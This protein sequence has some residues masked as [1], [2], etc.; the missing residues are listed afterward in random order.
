MRIAL[1]SNA[2]SNLVKG[3][4]STGRVVED[5]DE[6]WIPFIVLAEL[7]AG[8]ALGDRRVQNEQVLRRFLAKPGIGILYPDE[9]TTRAYAQ[10]F[11]QLRLAGRPIPTNDIWIAALADQHSLVLVTSDQHF[12][13]LPQLIL[14]DPPEQAD[15]G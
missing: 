13:Y 5:A 10:L 14:V 11:R 12:T 3:N 15:L 9:G 8:F 2:Y 4:L 7:R 6:V 1:D